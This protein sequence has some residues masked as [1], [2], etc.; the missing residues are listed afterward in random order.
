MKLIDVVDIAQKI[1]PNANPADVAIR[2]Q[3]YYNDLAMEVDTM[4]DYAWCDDHEDTPVFPWSKFKDKD[5]QPIDHRFQKALAVKL[6][7]HTIRHI[8]RSAHGDIVWDSDPEQLTAGEFAG[9]LN[10]APKI[11]ALPKGGTIGLEF[12][13]RPI[14]DLDTD[15]LPLQVFVPAIILRL[16]AD[17][18]AEKREWDLV[19]YYNRR[20][21]ESYRRAK[22]QF[23]AGSSNWKISNV[24]I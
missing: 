3:G 23:N 11:M 19:G 4:I 5:D 15:K 7:G 22:M 1:D 10:G 20:Y 6:N 8:S 24:E 14:V 2:L 16:R 12:V 21:S 9:D 17:L 18:H 13:A